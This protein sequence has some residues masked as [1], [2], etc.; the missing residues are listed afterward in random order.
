[1]SG[2]D[3]P[4]ERLPVA[5][6]VPAILDVLTRHQVAF[7]VIGGVAVA[8]HGYIRATKEVDI[9]PSPDAANLARL[10]AALVELEARPLEIGEF[11]PDEL[12]VAFGLE[13]LLQFGNWALATKHGRLELLQHITGKLETLEDYERLE[14]QA[15]ESRLPFGTVA[16]AS[17]EDLIDLKT[18]AGRDLD[19]V[20]IRALREARGDTDTFRGP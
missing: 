8:H 16:F 2:H 18:I 20:D 3:T 13:A 11:R 19:L 12:P 7:V 6:D 9:V 5:P 14:N 1:M 10:W 17:Y 4:A 15:D